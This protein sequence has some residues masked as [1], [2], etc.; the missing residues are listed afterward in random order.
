MA[1]KWIAHGST[2]PRNGTRKPS[3][4]ICL[5]PISGRAGHRSAVRFAPDQT[6]RKA[7]KMC[8]KSLATAASGL[9]LAFIVSPLAAQP[10]LP[11]DPWAGLYIGIGGH[12]GEAFGGEKLD[13]QDLSATHD[14]SFQA[15]S[16][17][18]RF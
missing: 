13:F 5:N 15:T 14:L 8:L 2:Q 10:N 4:R 12:A 7:R 1:G 6:K 17:D 9:I 18:S 16:D 3:T 11:A